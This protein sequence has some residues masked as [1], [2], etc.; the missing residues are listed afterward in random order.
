MQQMLLS[1][2]VEAVGDEWCYRDGEVVRVMQELALDAAAE[3]K[4]LR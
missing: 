2:G 3:V 1:G 4:L